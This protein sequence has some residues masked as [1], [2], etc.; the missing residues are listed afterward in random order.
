[1][2]EATGKPQSAL[3]S[4]LE[5]NSN[6]V[7]HTDRAF[8]GWSCTC[9]DEVEFRWLLCFKCWLVVT[10]QFDESEQNLGKES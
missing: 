4:E 1:M 7:K 8:I 9:A 10:G 6:E 5:F 2:T 3:V